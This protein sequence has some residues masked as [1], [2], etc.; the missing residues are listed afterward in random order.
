MP[1]ASSSVLLPS[2]S[3]CEGRPRSTSW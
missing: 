1:V 3:C 2:C